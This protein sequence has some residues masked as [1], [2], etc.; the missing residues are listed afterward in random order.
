MR[1]LFLLLLAT[2]A[3]AE[4]LTFAWDANSE[5]DVI[6]YRLHFGSESGD[7]GRAVN[8]GNV[9]Q[10]SLELEEGERF[11]VVTAYNA[12]GLESPPSNELDLQGDPPAP[13]E[14]R[15]LLQARPHDVQHLGSSMHVDL[16]GGDHATKRRIRPEQQLLP[17]LSPAIKRPRNLCA[18]PHRHRPS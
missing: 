8:C 17:S 3:H 4:L 7:Y 14:D 15:R 11:V 6:G 12:A 1:P 18:T 13:P 10:F 16:P 9:T 5:P 2:T